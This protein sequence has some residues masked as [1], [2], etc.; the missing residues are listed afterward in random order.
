[1]SQQFSTTRILGFATLT[2]VICGFFVASAAVALKDRQVK[3]EELDRKKQ[4]LVVAGIDLNSGSVDDLFASYIKP[5]LVDLVPNGCQG[6]QADKFDQMKAVKDPTKSHAAQANKAKVQT[7]PNCATVYEVLSKAD[8]SLESYILPIEGKGLWSTLY[9]F[10]AIDKTVAQ[11]TGITFY[12]HAETPGLGGEVDNPKWKASWKGKKPFD[13]Q[14]N[15][16]L[17]V[18]KG[19]AQG[20][21]QIDGLSGATLTSNGVSYLISYWLGKDGFGPYLQKLKK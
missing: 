4:V 7:K 20:D 1:M 17:K 6:E 11:V 16:L 10:I 15:V 14:F 12:K 8:K 13:D 5:T 3:N 18:V 21:S 2:C 9:G 19:K